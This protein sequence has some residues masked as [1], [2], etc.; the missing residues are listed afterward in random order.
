MKTFR[1]MFYTGPTQVDF[2]ANAL[3]EAGMRAMTGT[4][5]VYALVDATADDA[6]VH[7]MVA[8]LLQLRPKMLTEWI[9]RGATVVCEHDPATNP[10]DAALEASFTLLDPKTIEDGTFYAASAWPTL[11][12]GQRRVVGRDLAEMLRD[13]DGE[14]IGEC[15]AKLASRVSPAAMSSYADC[16]LAGEQRKAGR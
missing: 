3:R 6:A 15:A 14:T 13:G 11:T 10:N 9:R 4:E 16:L 8:G 1:V 7:N 2:W 5:K 12:E